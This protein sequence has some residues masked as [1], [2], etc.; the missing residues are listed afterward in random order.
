MQQGHCVDRPVD[1]GGS[2]T[3]AT[4]NNNRLAT[5]HVFRRTRTTRILRET[6]FLCVLCFLACLDLI[7]LDPFALGL[8][9]ARPHGT[10]GF[11]RLRPKSEQ[12]RSIQAEE[13]HKKRPLLDVLRNERKEQ[14]QVQL[15][16]HPCGVSLSAYWQN[17]YSNLQ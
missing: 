6:G 5:C 17:T 10:P 9:E 15:K 7:Q 12:T 1:D 16:W 4:S 11:E 8:E 13:S 2:F 14:V 3:V